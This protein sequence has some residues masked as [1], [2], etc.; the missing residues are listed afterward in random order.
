ML[1]AVSPSRGTTATR[2]HRRSGDRDSDAEEVNRSIAAETG[3][4]F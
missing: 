1:P 2:D 3:I 4:E